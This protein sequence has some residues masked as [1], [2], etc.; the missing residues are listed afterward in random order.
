MKTA[1]RKE[2]NYERTRSRSTSGPGRA[3]ESRSGNTGGPAPSAVIRGQ[4]LAKTRRERI[5]GHGPES[6]G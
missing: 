2:Q 4:A 6:S 3:I 5:F 1:K